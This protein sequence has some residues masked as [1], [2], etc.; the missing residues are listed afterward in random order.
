MPQ[1]SLAEYVESLD[2]AGLLTRYND[3]KRV[4]ELPVLMEANP[5]A[6]IFVEKVKDSQLPFFANVYGAWPMYAL[7][8]DCDAKKIG[9]EIAKR[10]ERRIKPEL[11]KTAP[12]K[13]VVL[14]GRDIDLTNFPLFIHHPR[15]GHAYFND[16][17]VRQ[18]RPGYRGARSGNLAL[19]VLV[20][21]RNQY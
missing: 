21:D 17:N 12:C 3:E 16:T 13:D 15:D 6:A 20:E 5:D 11:V 19:H 14:K 1:G 10:S 7:A 9:I 4:D 8:L 2:K 18:P